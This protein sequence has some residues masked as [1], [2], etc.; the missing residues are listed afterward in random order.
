MKLDDI[1]LP[2][3]KVLKI[4]SLGTE[5]EFK[6]IK[7]NFFLVNEFAQRFLPVHPQGQPMNCEL[8]CEVLIDYI[9]SWSLED[10]LTKENLFKLMRSRGG[11]ISQLVEAMSLIIAG[12]TSG[13]I[14][15]V[16]AVKKN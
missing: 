5:I 2:E 14:E 1:K 7:F 6:L 9:E 8:A 12:F 16:D 15:E 13:T 3:A 11:V 10:E 4:S